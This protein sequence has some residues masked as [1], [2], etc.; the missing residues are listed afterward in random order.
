M[1]LSTTFSIALVALLLERLVGY[2]KHLLQ[3]IGHPVEWMGRLISALDRT[4]NSAGS[5]KWLRQLKGVLALLVLIVSVAAVTVPLSFAC[6]SF[7]GGWVIEALLAVPFLAQVDLRRYVGA[8]AEGLDIGLEQGRAA[9]SHIVGRDPSALDESGVA[10]AALESL[11]ENT[12]D[13]IVAPLFWLALFGLPGVAIYKAI[14]TADSMIGHKNERYFHFGWAAA[15]LDDLV[16][17]PCSRLTAFL[18]AAAA[19][20]TSPSRGAGAFEVMMSDA[21]R[22]F[23]PNAGWPE[24]A[25]AGALE[26]RL[27]GPRYYQGV[28]V[29][30][31]WIGQGRELLAASD[32]REGLK[33][34]GRTL[35]LLAVLMGIGVIFIP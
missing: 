34:Q 28:R 9:V 18:I 5:S 6:R 4:L 33:L 13:A 20:L 19:S 31:S 17:L 11:A 10:R 30:L 14:N 25:M 8:V 22:H 26:V 27:G 12:S 21:K 2:P 29:D 35:T 3:Q 24:A 7:E 15:R 1:D 23:S 32:I 16:N